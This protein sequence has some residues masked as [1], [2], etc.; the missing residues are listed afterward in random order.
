MNESAVEPADDEEERLGE[1]G[2]PAEVHHLLEFRVDLAQDGQVL[3]ADE[4][5]EMVDAAPADGGAD[6]GL[7]LLFE[8]RG[9]RVAESDRLHL[10]LLLGQEN[11]GEVSVG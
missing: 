9:D 8:R 2:H 1:E 5:G 10:G 4:E 7:G 6:H 3:G 11:G